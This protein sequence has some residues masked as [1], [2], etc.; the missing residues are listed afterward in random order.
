LLIEFQA[1]SGR[2]ASFF[3]CED[4]KHDI[5]KKQEGCGRAAFLLY[6]KHS[7]QSAACIM[8]FNRIFPH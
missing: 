4:A 2:A 3:W 6:A 7:R 1:A 5:R 8:R